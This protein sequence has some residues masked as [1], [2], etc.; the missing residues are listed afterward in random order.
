[1]S[2]IKVAVVGGGAS[3]LVAAI[4]ASERHSVTLFERNDR[5]GKKLLAAGNGRCNLSNFGITAETKLK[6]VYN[7]EFA[8]DFVRLFPY[9]RLMGFFNGI[10]LELAADG[11]GRVYPYSDHASSVLDV[12]RFKCEQSGVEVKTGVCVESVT[13]QSGGFLLMLQGG[14]KLLFDRVILC[15]GSSAQAKAYNG[16]KLADGLKLKRTQCSPSLCPI[17]TFT[18]PANLNG[19][20]IKCA[21]ALLKNGEEA[22]CEKGEILFREYGLS[23]IAVFNLSAAIARDIACGIKAQY[24]ISLDLFP[25]FSFEGL[26]VKL[27]KRLNLNGGDFFTGLLTRRLGEEILK[28]A[29]CEKVN[30]GNLAKICLCLKQWKHK[31]A[32][33]SDDANC[34]AVSGGVDLTQINADMSVKDRSG[35]FVCG[36]FLDVDGLCGG[37]NLHFAFASGLIAGASV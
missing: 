3:G 21:A 22:A 20:R 32:G 8:A 27:K 29:Q 25:D 34:Q 26:T 4:A 14:E 19:M 18:P 37:Y 15:I 6:G 23:G 36:E 13:E 7:S 30:E 24:E 16:K 17:K 1:M 10:G 12:L 35:L 28:Y 9:E 31:V 5:A 2:K 11:E 33:L